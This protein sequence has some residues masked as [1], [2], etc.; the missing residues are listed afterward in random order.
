MCGAGLLWGESAGYP[1]IMTHVTQGKVVP[2]TAK[3]EMHRRMAEPG[4]AS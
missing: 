3:A 4:P 1:A 2:D